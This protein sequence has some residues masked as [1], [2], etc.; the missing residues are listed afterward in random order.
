MFAS[1]LIVAMAVTSNSPGQKE[2]PTPKLKEAIEVTD[3]SGYYVVS[4]T[5]ANG[6][7]YQGIALILKKR[8][9]HFVSWL[10]PG[11]GAF[12][13]V[14]IKVGNSF[15]VSWS[16]QGDKGIV[17]GVNLYQIEVGN[18]RPSL[19]GKWAALP[20]PGIMNTETLRFLR[21]LDPEE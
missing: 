3:L 21:P 17:R 5:E 19:T 1:V 18:A 6:K 20:G 12:E 13:G 11:N 14:G 9:I 16:V 8:D 4:G 15:S 10:I 2:P 7:K